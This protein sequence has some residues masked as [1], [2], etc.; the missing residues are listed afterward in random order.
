MKKNSKKSQTAQPVARLGLSHGY[1][2]DGDVTH[3]NASIEI[4][5]QTAAMQQFWAL[6]LWACEESEQE[7]PSQG[8]KIAEVPFG[9]TFAEGQVFA[10]LQGSCIALPPPGKQAYR[11]F[12]V[13]ASGNNP[14]CSNVEDFAA[15]SQSKVFVQP[16][17][18]GTITCTLNE[19]SVLLG[20]DEISNPRQE[21]NLSGTL[22]LEL[23]SL[24]TPY[25]GG[26]WTGCPVASMIL[27]TLSG[28]CRWSGC[29]YTASS[30]TPA[31]NGYLTL[32]LREWTPAGYVTRDYRPLMEIQPKAIAVDTPKK[33]KPAKAAS[34]KPAPEA[35]ETAAKVVAA[36]G[37]SVNKASE[38]EL[39][40]VKGLSAAVARAIIASRPY[41][42]LEELCRAKGVGEKLLSK[43]R[44]F[45]TL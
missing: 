45:L 14:Y 43:V 12:M 19:T 40:S 7:N 27:G 24:D 1:C 6:Q 13:L 34:V 31:Q 42:S 9:Q 38:S 21:D 33:A 3:L 8:I 30:A 26:Q 20:I 35:K 18:N 11:L 44:K 17:L 23:W 37:V 41:A 36:S 4:L 29:E 10:E 39:T 16:S 25:A 28:Q 5:E 15:Y 22:S 2:F 32:M